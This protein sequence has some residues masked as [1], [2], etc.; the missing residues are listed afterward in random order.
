MG[1]SAQQSPMWHIVKA[2]LIQALGETHAT[3]NVKTE[4]QCNTLNPGQSVYHYVWAFNPE[5]NS[6]L[7]YRTN[8]IITQ[9]RS[10][11]FTET[12]IV[13]FSVFLIRY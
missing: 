4:D 1:T 13:A 6:S 8:I 12:G 2:L 10:P 5:K 11:S 7:C 9:A 3:S